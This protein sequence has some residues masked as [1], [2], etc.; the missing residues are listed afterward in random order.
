MDFWG[1]VKISSGATN[2]R[3]LSFLSY[4]TIDLGVTDKN[5]TKNVMFEPIITKIR[6]FLGQNVNF[7]PWRYMILYWNFQMMDSI[8][9]TKYQNVRVSV[10]K[11]HI[12]WPLKL[13]P[14]RVIN[15]YF[16]SVTM[17][18]PVFVF[19]NFNV[20]KVYIFF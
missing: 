19:Q 18:H 2:L 6:P 16:C 1:L 14:V 15:Q 20:K 4:K 5:K 12:V 9:K 7:W 17:W 3:F 8:F 13:F 11:W 10:K